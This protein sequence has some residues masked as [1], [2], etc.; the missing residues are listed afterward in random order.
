M[1]PKRKAYLANCS[2]RE[3]ELRLNINKAKLNLSIFKMAVTKQGML[4]I[5][6][7]SIK[8]TKCKLV[9]YRHELTRIKGMDRVVV[10]RDLTVIKKIV[11]VYF[12]N[13]AYGVCVCGEHLVS[14]EHNF[15]PKCGRKILWNK[16]K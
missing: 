10:P 2:E 5:L 4:P 1:T 11:G 3:K 9:V 13:V 12:C 16:V 7:K 14:I 15:C 8:S 6:K